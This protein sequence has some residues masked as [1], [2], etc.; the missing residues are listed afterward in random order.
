MDILRH[1]L[2]L[3]TRAPIEVADITD[4]VRT[5]VRASGVRAGL[6]TLASL[7]TTARLTINEREAEL[8]R[9]MVAFLERIAPR[10]AGYRHDVDTVDGRANAHAHLLGLFVNASES[11]VVADGDLVLGDWQ[12]IFFVELDGPRARREVA[13]HLMGTR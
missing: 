4:P 1:T 13:L 5:W 10:G 12:A 11:V 8:Q 6:L 9:D 2:A 3:A 7:H